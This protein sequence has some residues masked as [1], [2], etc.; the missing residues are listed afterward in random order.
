MSN[1]GKL[2]LHPVSEDEAELINTGLVATRN[3]DSGEFDYS[4]AEVT[5]GSEVVLLVTRDN[6][7]GTVNGVL[8]SDGCVGQ[9]DVTNVNP[10][11]T[12]DDT[13]DEN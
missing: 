4:H 10:D 3:P 9:I 11:D 5:V 1:L 7:D 13:P 12:P 6:D 8:F 2:L